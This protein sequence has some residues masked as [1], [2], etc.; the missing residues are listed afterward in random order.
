MNVCMVGHGMMGTW[1]SDSLKDFGCTLH[2]LVGREAPKTEAFAVDYEYRKW[3]TDYSAAVS[4]DEIDIIIIAGPSATHASMAIQALEAGK[5]VLVEIPLALNYPD[6]LEVVELAERLGLT[7][8]VVHPMRFRREHVE[9][10]K[11]VGAGE[12]NVRHVH[13]RLFL[14]RLENVGSTGLHRSWTDN[15]LWHHGAHLVDVGLWLAGGGVPQRAAARIT[16]SFA[17]MPPPLPKT[18]IPMELAAM[19]ETDRQQTIVCTGSYHSQE[20]MFDIFVVT[21]RE[22]Y[23]LDILKGTLSLSGR[24]Q[25]VQSEKE[26]NAQVSRDFVSAVRGG[27]APLVTGRSVLPAMSILQSIEDEQAKWWDAHPDAEARQ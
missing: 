12:E 3:T 6:A 18:G 27:K 8:G 9:L 24:E 20:R 14:H 2:T 17:I 5:H 22:A 26:N 7:L 16:R 23:R 25:P 15:L 13:S 21:D 19:I 1:H 11:R 4:D 10:C